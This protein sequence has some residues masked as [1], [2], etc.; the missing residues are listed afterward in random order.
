LLQ[1]KPET[2][3]EIIHRQGKAAVKWLRE[4]W[5]KDCN[6]KPRLVKFGSSDS[7]DANSNYAKSIPSNSPSSKG[8]RMKRPSIFSEQKAI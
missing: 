1:E 2:E 6:S 8:S 4:Y 7:S 3:S 5:L